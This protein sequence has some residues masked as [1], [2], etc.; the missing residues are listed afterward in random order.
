MVCRCF[1]SGQPSEC[2]Q[3]KKSVTDLTGGGMSECNKKGEP[4]CHHQLAADLWLQLF[5][6]LPSGP[7]GDGGDL[8][9]VVICFVHRRLGRH[10]CSPTAK[11]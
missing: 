6:S 11:T 3:Q 2:R 5:L 8:V 10:N 1:Y 7:F 4:A 9:V